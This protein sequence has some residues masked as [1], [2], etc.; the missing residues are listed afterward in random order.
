M[1]SCVMPMMIE[2][3]ELDE[4]FGDMVLGAMNRNMHIFSPEACELTPG[5][6]LVVF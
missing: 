1:V 6:N 5:E 4:A 3:R 2:T